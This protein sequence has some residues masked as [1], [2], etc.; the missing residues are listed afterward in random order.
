MLFV[1]VG[2]LAYYDVV[3]VGVSIIFFFPEEKKSESENR[4]RG[5]CLCEAFYGCFTLER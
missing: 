5:V 1:P 3:I 2:T 4:E